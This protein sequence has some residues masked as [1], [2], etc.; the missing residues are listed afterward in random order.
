M[1]ILTYV[2]HVIGWLSVIV[3][4]WYILG[5]VFCLTDKNFMSEFELKVPRGFVVSC[6]LSI[7][8]LTLLATM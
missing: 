8:Y 6:I 5:L 1:N 7:T 4:W 3:F 2:M